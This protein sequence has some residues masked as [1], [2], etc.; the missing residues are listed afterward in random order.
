[1]RREICLWVEWSWSEGLLRA[2]APQDEIDSWARALAH[3]LARS[4]PHRFGSI[5]VAATEIASQIKRSLLALSYGQRQPEDIHPARRGYL[6]ENF[7]K[8]VA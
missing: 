1:M 4:E 5:E 7:S 2:N 6:A 3:S 8:R